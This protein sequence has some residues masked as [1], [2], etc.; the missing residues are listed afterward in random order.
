MTSAE[1]VNNSWLGST[2]SGVK[3]KMGNKSLGLVKLGKF[4]QWKRKV[5]ENCIIWSYIAQSTALYFATTSSLLHLS[6]IE[7]LKKFQVGNRTTAQPI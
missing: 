3:M 6:W 7:S 1:K 2:H 4:G 5:E